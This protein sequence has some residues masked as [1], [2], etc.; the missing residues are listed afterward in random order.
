[1]TARHVKNKLERRGKGGRT[2]S[3][4]ERHELKI[5]RR[6]REPVDKAAARKLD[7]YIKNLSAIYPQK[8]LIAENLRKKVE[9][10]IYD[11]KKAV[12]LWLSWVTEGARHYMKDLGGPHDTMLTL[13]FNK[14]T[15]ER[16]AADLAENY[17]PKT[18][19]RRNF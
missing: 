4:F 10:H 17:G 7:L 2:L 14:P 6:R 16:V 3:V 12:K 1:M 8:R 13:G 19:L 11:P 15:R 9:K 18:L 5:A